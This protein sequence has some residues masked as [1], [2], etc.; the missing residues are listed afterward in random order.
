MI[1]AMEII[2]I[3]DDVQ[4]NDADPTWHTIS[5]S[6]LAKSSRVSF[7]TCKSYAVRSDVSSVCRLASGAVFE[8]YRSNLVARWS[9]MSVTGVDQEEALG[10]LDI[11]NTI[12][13]LYKWEREKK[14]RLASAY[15][16]YFVESNF[17]KRNLSAVNALLLSASV[18]RLTEWSMVAILR[19]SYSSRSVLPAWSIFLDAVKHRLKDNERAER[20]LMG[21]NR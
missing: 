6:W 9:N 8:N 14:G 17:S 12:E 1:N 2:E 13:L 7:G 16:V 3:N 19:S 20:L 5:T 11:S 4:R 21:L 18:E 10:L 15:A